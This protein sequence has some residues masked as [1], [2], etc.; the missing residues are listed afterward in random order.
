[1]LYENAGEIL[2]N[3]QMNAVLPLFRHTRICLREDSFAD[4]MK[5]LKM[6]ESLSL[7]CSGRGGLLL[8]RSPF[9]T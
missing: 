1:M 8:V 9:D 3:R 6:S 7:D 4:E 2:C 5:I